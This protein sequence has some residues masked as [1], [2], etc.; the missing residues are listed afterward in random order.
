M[1]LGCSPRGL[2][3]IILKREALRSND[4]WGV[5]LWDDV[6]PLPR[7]RP[8]GEG[9][10]KGGGGRREWATGGCVRCVGRRLISCSLTSIIRDWTCSMEK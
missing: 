8:G 6:V 3:F 5:R 9:G 4:C 2:V 1:N 10:R 7:P